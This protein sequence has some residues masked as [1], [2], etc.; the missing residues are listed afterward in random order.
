MISILILLINLAINIKKIN[1]NATHASSLLWYTEEEYYDQKHA[2]LTEYFI[3]LATIISQLFHIKLRHV[4]KREGISRSSLAYEQILEACKYITT[5]RPLIRTIKRDRTRPRPFGPQSCGYKIN[6]IGEWSVSLSQQG[7]IE[8]PTS[9]QCCIISICFIWNVYLHYIKV[10][11]YQLIFS[12]DK[13]IIERRC[14][15][16]IAVILYHSV[17][18]RNIIV[19]KII[20]L[21]HQEENVSLCI[22]RWHYSVQLIIILFYAVFEDFE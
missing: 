20:F 19:K 18:K 6:I 21:W 13:I 22:I 11:L 3:N 1:Q 17:T 10:P 15:H 4:I 7:E 9:Q 5:L 8:S 2:L 12:G 16:I 14:K